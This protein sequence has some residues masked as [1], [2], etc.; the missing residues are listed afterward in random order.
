MC[1]TVIPEVPEAMRGVL[2]VGGRMETDKREAT[3]DS[4]LLFFFFSP[5]L[6][7]REPWLQA[8]ACAF[9]GLREC[10]VCVQLSPGCKRDQSALP[11]SNNSP[12]L[13][14]GGVGWKE[15][16]IWGVSEG[17]GGGCVQRRVDILN[18]SEPH[19]YLIPK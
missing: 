2:A 16:R 12:A 4:T 1:A 9:S 19:L 17:R 5:P 10:E 3:A 13:A 7:F 14:C 11:L 15:I 6:L 18:S 8:G